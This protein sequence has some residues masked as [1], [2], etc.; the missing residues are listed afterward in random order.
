MFLVVILFVSKLEDIVAI[1]NSFIKRL[2]VQNTE[3]R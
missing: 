2:E 1:I 3:K